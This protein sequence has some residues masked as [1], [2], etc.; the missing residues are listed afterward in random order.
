MKL[1][2][3]KE[4]ATSRTKRHKFQKFQTFF[5]NLRSL[6]IVYTCC[7]EIL[8]C[9]NYFCNLNIRMLQLNSK[10]PYMTFE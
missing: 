3:S 5:L 6:E 7:P 8:R 9:I 2:F 10:H 1:L 4:T